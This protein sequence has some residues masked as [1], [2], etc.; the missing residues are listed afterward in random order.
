M[1]KYQPW[2]RKPNTV[3]GSLPHMGTICLTLPSAH[4]ILTPPPFTTSFS[5][6]DNLHGFVKQ[7]VGPRAMFLLCQLGMVEFD[8]GQV[9]DQDTGMPGRLTPY[10]PGD[11]AYGEV[12]RIGCSS[13]AKLCQLSFVSSNDNGSYCAN[14]SNYM[15]K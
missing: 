1:D 4:S 15:L 5:G 2:Y 12:N 9:T 14:C 8:C 7:T 11:V 3:L 6:E 13:V 10:M